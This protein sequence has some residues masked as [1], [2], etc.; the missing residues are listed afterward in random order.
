MTLLGSGLLLSYP[1]GPGQNEVNFHL[2]SGFP[3]LPS[4]LA[5]DSTVRRFL[6]LLW[7]MFRR[8]GVPTLWGPLRSGLDRN[9]IPSRQLCIIRC[10]RIPT[11]EPRTI[12][13]KFLKTIS[14]LLVVAG[15]LSIPAIS[16]AQA[17]PPSCETDGAVTTPATQTGL[18]ADCEVLLAAKET[19][20]GTGSL[21]WSAGLEISAWDGVTVDH[22][23][24]R[25]TGIDLREKLLTGQFPE[26]LAN[27]SH[28]R[29]LYLNH[30]RLTGPIPS[31]INSLASLRVLDLGQNRLTGMIPPEL[32]GLT[33][34]RALDLADN[35]LTGMI[36]GELGSQID[37]VE[38]GR[39]MPAK[40]YRVRLSEEE[41]Q[42]LKGL[43]SKGRGAAYKQTHARI[44]LLSDESQG[45]GG[46][47]DED[48]AR[49]LQ[50]GAA[51]V[52]RVRRR[53][54]AEGIE[55]ALG[56]REQVNR[57][58]KKLDGSGEAALLILPAWISAATAWLAR[59]RMISATC[60]I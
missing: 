53:C 56:R 1:L 37:W 12:M 22:Q 18:V 26:A 21:N 44:L 39:G 30:N 20:V 32:G 28:L 13:P 16:Q 6:P 23:Q 41:R 24:G 52:E 60:S 48:V 45:E 27:L 50:I 47:K 9:D 51:T 29:V 38:G 2:T 19:L 15:L 14:I 33:E 36:P 43:V 55:A 3:P 40:K 34:V 35:R 11:V 59:C 54:V 25:V 10:M 58:P 42:E 57:R 17:S 8:T 46:M 31:G 49:S 5:W 4:G 7:E